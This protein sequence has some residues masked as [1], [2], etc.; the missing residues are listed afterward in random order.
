[1]ANFQQLSHCGNYSDRIERYVA[2]KTP[3]VASILFQAFHQSPPMAAMYAS[4][5][6]AARGLAL[7]VCHCSRGSAPERAA[8]FASGCCGA[9]GAFS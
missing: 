1:M 3:R 7:A 2:D 6:V 8:N 5:P 9:A 4:L